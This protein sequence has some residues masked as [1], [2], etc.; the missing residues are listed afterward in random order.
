M[1]DGER[2]CEIKNF[3]WL[4]VLVC[5]FIIVLKGEKVRKR[6]NVCERVDMCV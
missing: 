4:N 3:D 5:L 6:L 1:G 2:D